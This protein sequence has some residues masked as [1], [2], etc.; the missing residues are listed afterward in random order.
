MIFRTRWKKGKPKHKKD[1][2]S[3]IVIVLL[4]NGT[5]APDKYG[6]GYRGEKWVKYGNLVRGWFYLPREEWTDDTPFDR[7]IKSCTGKGWFAKS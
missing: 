4:E 5:I 6:Y 7:F 2:F 1:G 3:E